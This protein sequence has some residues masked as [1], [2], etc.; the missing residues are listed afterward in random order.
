MGSFGLW[1]AVLVFPPDTWALLLFSI[2]L[3]AGLYVAAT[4]SYYAFFYEG[5]LLLSRDEDLMTR[6]L[7]GGVNLLRERLGQPPI[8]PV[9]EDVPEK[10]MVRVASDWL[11]YV[12][13][14]LD[15]HRPRRGRAESNKA[16]LKRLARRLAANMV[17]ALWSIQRSR[18]IRERIARMNLPGSE[19]RIRR[20][21]QIEQRDVQRMQHSFDS[22]VTLAMRLVELGS[23]MNDDDVA[24]LLEEFRETAK[25]IEED[26]QALDEVRS[27]TLKG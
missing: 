8:W 21:Q 27:N 26:T 24:R 9:P 5:L 17:E 7:I 18:E 15:K 19:D 16:T 23:K 20:M 25:Q 4:L 6:D 3:G 12:Q 22:L 2:L 13:K 14:E 1:I 10:E 11:L